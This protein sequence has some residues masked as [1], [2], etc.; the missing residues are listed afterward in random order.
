MNGTG[1]RQCRHFIQ[2]AARPSSRAAFVRDKGEKSGEEH[3][4]EPA[5]RNAYSV[6]RCAS[7]YHGRMLEA[8]RALNAASIFVFRELASDVWTGCVKDWIKFIVIGV[9]DSIG[10]HAGRREIELE[11]VG[12]EWA[13]A[14]VGRV[15]AMRHT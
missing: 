12:S 13:R 8:G 3:Y 7:A 2:K 10:D 15:E 1:H 11:A 9:R 14:L 6:A 4:E 5:G